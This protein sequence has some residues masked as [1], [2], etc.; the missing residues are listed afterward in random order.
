MDQ[1]TN[2][3]SSTAG[4]THLV[5]HEIIT[6][7]GMVVRQWTYPVPEAHRQVIKEDVG[8]MLQDGI[9]EESCSPFL[10]VPKPDGKWRLCNDFRRLSTILEFNSYPLS[11]WGEPGSSPPLISPRVTGKS[12]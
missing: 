3:L 8:Q 7:L 10:V 12:H 1:F 5:H 2:I 6:P 9:I 4:M 11:G